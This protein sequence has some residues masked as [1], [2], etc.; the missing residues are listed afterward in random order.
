VIAPK[1]KALEAER[2]AVEE[3]LAAADDKG[4]PVALHPAAMNNYLADVRAMRAALDDPEAAERPEPIA[5]L[6]RLIH[7]VVIHAQPGVKGAFDVEIKG[8]LQEL[9]GAPFL[10]RSVGRGLVVAEGGILRHPHVTPKN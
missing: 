7:S 3:K 9:L 1:L 8:R 6:R 5:P 4:K 10:R 2:L